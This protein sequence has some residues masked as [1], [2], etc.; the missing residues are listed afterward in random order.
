MK[1]EDGRQKI[2]KRNSRFRLNGSMVQPGTPHVVIVRCVDMVVADEFIKTLSE[3]IDI[4]QDNIAE[5]YSEPITKWSK[6]EL[7][8]Q[9][10]VKTN[11]LNSVDAL[12]DFISSIDSFVD[13]DFGTH[14]QYLIH[15][16][17]IYETFGKL[18]PFEKFPSVLIFRTL[19]EKAGKA[20]PW[21]R[22]SQFDIYAG[23]ERN[24]YL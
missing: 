16:C 20:G 6:F 21:F 5:F 14:P 3:A 10:F 13:K 9:Y 15:D 4:T 7:D 2:S 1:P 12:G 8:S 11:T 19:M 23:K 17:P 22:V 24:K 18:T